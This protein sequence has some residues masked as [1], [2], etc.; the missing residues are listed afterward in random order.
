M[1]KIGYVFRKISQGLDTANQIRDTVQEGIDIKNHIGAA[2]RY[3]DS[4]QYK[5][6]K[7]LADKYESKERRWMICSFLLWVIMIIATIVLCISGNDVI[8]QLL[9]L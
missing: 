7:K 2:K 4:G 1:S 5:R 8:L 6:D 9:Y 3:H